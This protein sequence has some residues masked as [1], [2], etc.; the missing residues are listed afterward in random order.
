MERVVAREPIWSFA[1]FDDLRPRDLYDIVGIRNAVFIVEQ[2]C[3][4]L[5]C[6]GIDTVSHHLWTRDEGGD[7]A[8]YLRVIPPGVAYPEA[9][10]GRIV[11]S[12]KARRT[13][14]GRLLMREGIRRIEEMYGRLPIRIGAQ[15]YLLRFYG[16]FGFRSTGREY[17]EDGIPHTE[18]LRSD[19]TRIP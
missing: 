9:S 12:P 5:D 10:L 14:L 4:Y 18:M 16:E 11:T 17:D 19:A 2:R 7:L 6:D 13:G 1:H 3:P 15:R 8:A